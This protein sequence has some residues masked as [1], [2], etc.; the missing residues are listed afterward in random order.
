[1]AT[2]VHIPG[3][4]VMVDGV[5]PKLVVGI[6]T[7][8]VLP[9]GKKAYCIVPAFV[10]VLTPAPIKV[11]FVELDGAQPNVKLVE[12]DTLNVGWAAVEVIVIY[13]GALLQP[14]TSFTVTTVT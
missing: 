2:K 1:M 3:I 7:V 5:A 11:K 10:P 4:A 8:K 6:G 9:G 12:L 14:F 13:F